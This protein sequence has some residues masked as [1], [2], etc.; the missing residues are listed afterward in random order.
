MET[1]KS[2]ELLF[3]ISV[4]STFFEVGGV[5]GGMTMVIFK[6]NKRCYI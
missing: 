3:V 6:E 5:N 1:K 4:K 2:K